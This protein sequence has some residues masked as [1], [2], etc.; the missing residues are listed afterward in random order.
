[1]KFRVLEGQEFRVKG[2]IWSR[3]LG[4]GFSRVPL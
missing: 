2:F 4:L 1:M 3:S